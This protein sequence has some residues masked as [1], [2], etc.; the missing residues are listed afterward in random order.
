L[1]VS[2]VANPNTERVTMSI[3]SSPEMPHPLDEAFR[4]FEKD[5]GWQLS[6]EAKIILKEG[7]NAVGADKLG[8]GIYRRADQRSGAL[9]KLVDLMPQ[10]LERVRSKAAD[11]REG[12]DQVIG[13][14]FVL[15]NIR[16]WKEEFNCSC[17]PV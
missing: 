17:W 11:R 8:L 1:F 3:T 4:K 10:F 13:G 9:K 15:Q 14:V 12:S 5:T 16:M 2:I 6:R 7:Y